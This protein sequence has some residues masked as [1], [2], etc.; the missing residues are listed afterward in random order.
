MRNIKPP[1]R[2]KNKPWT[3]DEV[4][5]RL[6][7]EYELSSAMGLVAGLEKAIEAVQQHAVVRFVTGNDT[8]AVAIRSAIHPIAL[9]L[10]EAKA[11]EKAVRTKY[12]L[13]E[14]L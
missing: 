7:Q 2:P 5:T 14:G 1:V 3:E 10:K 11:I 6:N 9:K 13:P 4:A 12:K 8:D